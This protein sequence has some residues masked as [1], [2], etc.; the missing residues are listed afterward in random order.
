MDE[1]SP[2]KSTQIFKKSKTINQIISLIDLISII[3]YLQNLLR[4]LVKMSI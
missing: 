4:I 2:K 3:G 1:K